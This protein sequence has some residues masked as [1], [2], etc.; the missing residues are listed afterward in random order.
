M[1]DMY[2]NLRKKGISY[3]EKKEFINSMKVVYSP[4]ID[5][6][7]ISPSNDVDLNLAVNTVASLFSHLLV[8]KGLEIKKEYH[9][10]QFLE[11][12][13]LVRKDEDI[14]SN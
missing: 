12:L 3:K 7:F 9:K 11:L 4:V 8:Q 5:N 10:R 14:K 1:K 6:N 13:E 2:S